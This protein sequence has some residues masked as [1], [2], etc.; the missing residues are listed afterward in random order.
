M[1]PLCLLLFFLVR[2]ETPVVNR[3]L[4]EEVNSRTWKR[5]NDNPDSFLVAKNIGDYLG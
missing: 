5:F 3:L 2:N 1:W 4:S